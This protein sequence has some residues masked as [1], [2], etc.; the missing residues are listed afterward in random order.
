MI[1]FNGFADNIFAHTFAL[2]TTISWGFWAN[3]NIGVARIQ[4]QSGGFSQTLSQIS[5]LGAGNGSSVGVT[6]ASSNAIGQ[7]ISTVDTVFIATSTQ[8]AASSIFVLVGV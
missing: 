1:V 4:F 8:G 2:P 7:L 5:A 6:N 3:G